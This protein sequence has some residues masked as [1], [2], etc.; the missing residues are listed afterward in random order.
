MVKAIQERNAVN[1][2]RQDILTGKVL[3]F[4]EINAKIE[5]VAPLPAA[6]PAA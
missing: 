2:I 5:E 6:T 1:E 3:D 4:L